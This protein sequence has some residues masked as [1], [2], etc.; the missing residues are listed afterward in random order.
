MTNLTAS[1][2]AYRGAAVA[3]VSALTLRVIEQALGPRAS[4][5]DRALA[6]QAVRDLIDVAQW[7]NVELPPV[8]SKSREA[9]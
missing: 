9:A 8:R 2:S 6:R 5:W 3:H 1:P 4:E 7:R